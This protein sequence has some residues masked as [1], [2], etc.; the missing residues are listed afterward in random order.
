MTRKLFGTDGIPGFGQQIPDDSEIALKVGMAAGRVF[1]TGDHTHRVVIGKDTRLSGYMIESALVSGFTS[2]G[3]DVFQFG[4][5][6]RRR[7]R[8]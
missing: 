2:V 6:R 3:M 8:C 7:W 5:L 1:T 4:P